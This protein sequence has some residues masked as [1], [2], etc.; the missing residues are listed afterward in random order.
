MQPTISANLGW[1]SQRTPLEEQWAGMPH[2]ENG[3]VGLACRT[4]V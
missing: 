1:A 2:G 4:G 3:V